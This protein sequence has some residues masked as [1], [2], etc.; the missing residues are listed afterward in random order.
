MS[1]PNLGP[2]TVIGN[3]YQLGTC[4]GYGGSSATYVAASLDRREVVLKLF[5]PAIRQRADIMAAIEQTYAASNALPPEIVIPLVD[6][7]YDSATGAPFSASERVAF[8]S[9]SQVAMQR[10]LGPDESVKALSLM[11]RALDQAHSRQL[12][13][14]ALKPT[15]VFLGFAQGQG[16]RISDFGAGLARIAVPTQEGYV[17]AVPWLAPEQVQSTSVASGPADVFSAAL[18][19]FYALTGRSYWRATQGTVDIAAWQRELLDARTPPSVRAR[20]SRSA[21]FRAV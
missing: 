18:V 15:N 6:A 21:T 9:L 3:K 4:I 2:G 17:H 13:H 12:F 7:G 14:H 11:A 20:E 8:P 1:A 16:V 10:P 5:D 19:I